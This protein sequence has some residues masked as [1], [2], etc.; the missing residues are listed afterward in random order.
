MEKLQ[1]FWTGIRPVLIE[2][3]E[4]VIGAAVIS[5][6]VA[7]KIA[8]SRKKKIENPKL[9]IESITPRRPE[10]ISDEDY[11]KL[12]SKTKHL[13]FVHG[14]Y[15][16]SWCWDKFMPFFADQGYHVHAVN[17]RGHYGS[18]GDIPSLTL[19]D[20]VDD[21]HRFISS[22][23]SKP[24]LIGHSAG[25]GISQRYIHVHPGTVSGLITLGAFPYFGGWKSSFRW[26]ARVPLAGFLAIVTFTPKRLLGTPKVYKSAMFDDSTP[27]AEVEKYFKLLEDKESVHLFVGLNFQFCDPARNKGLPV[28]VIGGE[29]DI[30]FPPHEVQ[31]SAEGYGTKAL[32]FSNCGHN[33]MVEAR[34]KEIA[35]AMSGWMQKNVV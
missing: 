22:L 2:N 7:L 26:T 8:S 34:W 12:K 9:K 32:I 17:M 35:E 16:G 27:L 15:H 20:C 30:I 10:G 18:E 6:A 28:L 33:M 11:E 13:V 19:Q 4:Y 29:N 31:K 24:I 25:G 1:S 23:P 14:G 3:R 5:F 21:L